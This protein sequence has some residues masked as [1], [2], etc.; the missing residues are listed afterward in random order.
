VDRYAPTA[1]GVPRPR[2]RRSAWPVSLVPA[3]CLGV[4]VVLDLVN[5]VASCSG[6]ASDYS[7]YLTVML[8]I[9]G[10]G[11]TLGLA[12]YDVVTMRSLH[13]A[14]LPLLAIALAVA[15]TGAEFWAS[16]EPLPL[17]YYVGLPAPVEHAAPATAG[18][19]G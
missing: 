14:R 11:T 4:I 2:P 5:V 17:R 10:V 19:D 1:G 9:L 7:L 13:V 18:P 6:H 3:A 15:V 12:L 8:T 16:K